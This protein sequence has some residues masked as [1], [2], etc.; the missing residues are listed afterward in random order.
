MEQFAMFN[1]RELLFNS[2]GGGGGI[3]S[4]TQKNYTSS[5]AREIFTRAFKNFNPLPP[6]SKKHP[7]PPPKYPRN[8]SP[9]LVLGGNNAAGYSG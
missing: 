6:W 5:H 1:I 9:M 2:G 4:A 3:W 8:R 7:L